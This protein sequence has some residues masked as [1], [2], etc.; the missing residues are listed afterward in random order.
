MPLRLAPLITIVVLSVILAVAFK[1]G[2]FGWPL[3][4]I[5]LSWLFKYS[6]T[7]LDQLVVGASEA[8]VLSIDMVMKSIGEW[9]SLLPLILVV[10]AF[11][12]SGASAFWF[13]RVAAD[14]LGVAMLVCF[15][16]VLAVQGWTGSVG[17]SLSVSTCVKMARI[18]GAGYAW[19]LGV[20]S[21]FVAV[22]IVALSTPTPLTVR[23][24]LFIYTWL[25]LI[26]LTGGMV[27]AHR[28]EI[29]AQTGFLLKR[30]VEVTEEARA[31][32]REELVDSIYGAWRSGAPQNAWSTLSRHLETCENALEDLRYVHHRAL[33][34]DAGP[35][36]ERLTQEFVT[37]L[38]AADREGEALSVVRA[39]LRT[40]AS[41]R[42]RARD[43]LTR[44]VRIANATNDAATAHGLMRDLAAVHPGDAEKS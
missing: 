1:V 14:L 26:V 35:F 44:L 6:F 34:W 20:T 32:L 16:A 4:L 39:Q 40:N 18:L 9:R 43:D 25:I 8:P 36:A 27:H 28:D 15:P 29:E 24:G 7:F 3:A 2:V 42:P 11:V 33:S 10:G 12:L 23:L 31:K 5:L 13:G 21:L 22:C 41:F 37:R 17:Q 38:L 19:I 30:E